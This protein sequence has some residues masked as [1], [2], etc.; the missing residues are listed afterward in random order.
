[1]V[2][3]PRRLCFTVLLAA[4]LLSCGLEDYIYLEP[5]DP[6][7]TGDL[8]K[9]T[10]TLPPSGSQPQEFRSYII[11]Y[12]IY[13]GSDIP[14]PSDNDSQYINTNIAL[15]QDY[16]A[17]KPYT[18][19]DNVSPSAILSVLNGRRY[20][21]LA[22]SFDG[23]SEVS[24]SILTGSGNISL[25]FTNDTTKRAFL[26]YGGNEYYL[27]RAGGFTQLPNRRFL[28]TT[29]SGDLAD[30]SKITSETNIDVA[31]KDGGGIGS[32]TYVSMYILAFGTDKNFGAIFSRPTHV[33]VF[34]LPPPP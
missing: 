26:T 17:L 2:K 29:G 8:T 16:N 1:M 31:G 30:S 23:T 20:H 21:P 11:F 6:P 34:R 14:L 32:Y 10:I 27:F 25:D 3:R 4:A 12:R 33:G 9:T 5:V 28:N 18:S 19:N 7:G 24:G 13:I 15:D 22:L